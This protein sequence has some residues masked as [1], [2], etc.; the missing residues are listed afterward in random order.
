ME[1][2]VICECYN[3]TTSDVLTEIKKGVTDFETL[4]K[5][6]M[7]GSGCPP[8]QLQNKILFNQLLEDYN[9]QKNGL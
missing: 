1:E 7:I 6:I 5:S 3:I 4:Q 9:Y 2:K 8:C